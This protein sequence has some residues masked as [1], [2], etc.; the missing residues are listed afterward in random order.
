LRDFDRLAGRG[1]DRG[2]STGCSLERLPLGK[3]R[4][5]NLR[6]RIPDLLRRRSVCFADDFD[7]KRNGR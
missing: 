5:G 4:S 3:P 7:A 2:R 1:R 6:D